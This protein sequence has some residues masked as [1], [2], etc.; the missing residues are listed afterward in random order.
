VDAQYHVNEKVQDLGIQCIKLGLQVDER[1][2]LHEFLSEGLYMLVAAGL[3]AAVAFK[4]TPR[5]KGDQAVY[6]T[7]R[8][9]HHHRSESI[10]NK[11]NDNIHSGCDQA[12]QN[13]LP[14]MS[15]DSTSLPPPPSPQK[16][17][18]SWIW[19]PW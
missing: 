14:T 3:K 11:P 19:S 16:S 15:S 4:E 17:R 13:G 9:T 12:L 6:S 1:Y 10:E 2:R 8:H 18:S 7:S 5:Y